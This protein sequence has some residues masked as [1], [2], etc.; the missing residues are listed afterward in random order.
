MN[1][2]L[3]FLTLFSLFIKKKRGKRKIIDSRIVEIFLVKGYTRQAVK[4]WT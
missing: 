2:I 3:V 4:K 1:F